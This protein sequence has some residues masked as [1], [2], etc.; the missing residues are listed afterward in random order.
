MRL[1]GRPKIG[2]SQ[3]GILSV[4]YSVGGEMYDAVASQSELVATP[5][6]ASKSTGSRPVLSG[7]Q[8]DGAF[9]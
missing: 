8:A 2:L 6:L 5:R 7:N 3:L 9:T 1:Q 4:Q